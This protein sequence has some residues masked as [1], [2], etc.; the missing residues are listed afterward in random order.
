MVDHVVALVSNRFIQK[1]KEEKV[2]DH[3]K[4]HMASPFTMGYLDLIYMYMSSESLCGSM[5]RG[6]IYLK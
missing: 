1:K 2:E 4:L 3:A 6:Y 5:P